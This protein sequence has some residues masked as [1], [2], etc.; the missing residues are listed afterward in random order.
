MADPP[1]RDIEAIFLDGTEIDEALR[2]GVRDA[3]RI[4]K[5]LGNP[6]ATWRDNKVCWVQPED[7]PLPE[8]DAPEK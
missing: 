7:I 6:V 8:E 1:K 4:H 3:L 2:Q 5:L